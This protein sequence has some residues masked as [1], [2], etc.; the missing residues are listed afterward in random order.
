MIE[1]VSKFFEDGWEIWRWTEDDDGMGG[2]VEDW[3]KQADVEGRMR[4]LTGDK[5]LTAD[6]E[7]F[8]G[9]HRFYCFPTDI[10]KGDQLR[11]GSNNYDVKF[12]S[13]MMA[14]DRFMQVDCELIT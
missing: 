2:I 12:P 13:D 7:T 10:R 4:P 3:E 6:K 5:R 14:F 8:F 1:E 11:N 9:S